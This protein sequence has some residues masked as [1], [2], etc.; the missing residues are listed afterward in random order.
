MSEPTVAEATEAIYQS[1]NADNA[2]LDAHIATL[3]AALKREGL[4]EAVVDPARLAQ[5]NRAGRKM[6]QSYFRQR[7]VTVAFSA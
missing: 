3:K 2:D 4:T 7:G 5:N 1:L 6:M